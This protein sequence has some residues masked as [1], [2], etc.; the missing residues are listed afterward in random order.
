MRQH[1]RY[2]VL[3][4]DEDGVDFDDSASEG[5]DLGMGRKRPGGFGFDDYAFSCDREDL[6]DEWD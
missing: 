5:M 6:D 3:S 1:R 2:D 4:D